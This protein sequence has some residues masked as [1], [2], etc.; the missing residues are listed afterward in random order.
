MIVSPVEKSVSLRREHYTLTV[1]EQ[2]SG[3]KLTLDLKTL[4]HALSAL[5]ELG[6]ERC[7]R[8]N[9]GTVCLCGPCH[10]RAALAELDPDWRPR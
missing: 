9:C 5:R 10:A 1:G 3:P 8:S 7:H 6:Q 4:R 2:V